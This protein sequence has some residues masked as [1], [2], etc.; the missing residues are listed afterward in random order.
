MHTTRRYRPTTL[1]PRVPRSPSTSLFMRPSGLPELS[2]IC[3]RRAIAHRPIVAFLLLMTYML[4]AQTS[5]A[6]QTQT[7][8]AI[9][10]TVVVASRTP[11]L[12]DQVGVSVSVLNRDAMRA[13]G[14]PD[15]GSLLDTQP[16]VTVTMDGG[17]GKAAAVRIRGEEGYRTRIVLDGINIA[18]PSSPQISP[19]VEHLLSSGLTRVEILRG[20]QGLMWGA[21]AG[22][23]IL[24]STTDARS[25]TGLEGFLEAGSDHF[26]QGALS[27]VISTDRL[28]ASL[29]LGQLETDGIN[30]RD[31]DTVTADQDGY[32]N[33]TAH[34]A[35]TYSVNNAISLEIAATDISGDNEYDGCYDT[36]TFALIHDCED[37]YQQ[38]AWRLGTQF[39]FEAHDVSLSVSSSDTERAFFSAGQRSYDTR[40]ETDTFSLLGT[41]RPT[42]STRL[43][44]GIDQEEQSLSDGSTDWSRDNT[45]FYLEAQQKFDASIVTVGWRRDDNDDF[46][47]HDSWRVSGRLGL[48]GVAEDWAIRAATGTGFRAPSLYEIAYNNGPFSYPPASGTALLE[49]RSRGWELGLIGQVGALELEI[50]WFDQEI[51]NE[52][53]FDLASYS[54]YLQSVGTSESEGIEVVG[55]FPLTPN[56]GVE[57]N[58]TWMDATQ[59]TGA[60]RP[61][62]PE[63]TARLSLLWQQ[64]Q[65]SA[66]L[67]ARH[68]G[69]AMD[70]FLTEIDNTFTLDLTARWSVTPVLT[71]EARVLNLTDN[72]DQQLPG[73]RV[74]GTT[75][76]LGA[77]IGL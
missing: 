26:Y 24:M 55:S 63:Q 69:E 73:Y 20:P 12:I 7:K 54:G 23:V 15:L 21:D 13:L 70:P 74:P 72:T 57:G 16:G 49:E 17:Y 33:T 76:F 66:N 14:Y 75:A 43:T 31:I 32:E 10:E 3:G 8:D 19:R 41:W 47:E 44:Y 28:Q 67:T 11:D 37:E 1:L 62:R 58:V 9:E 40:G 39:S 25:K 35:M 18:D 60:D 61:Y 52:I 68:T 34:G 77:R 36:V 29:S 46:G 48:T 4:V 59:Q 5:L 56:W 30:A 22:G 45:G 50:I 64:N 27:G 6:Q 71:L 42:E 51:E 65:W 38:Q 2:R 53:V